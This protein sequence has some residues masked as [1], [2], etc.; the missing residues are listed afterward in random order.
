MI[1]FLERVRE[2]DFL[3]SFPGSNIRYVLSLSFEVAL[4]CE[5]Y[6]NLACSNLQGQRDPSISTEL[7]KVAIGFAYR[8]RNILGMTS[9]DTVFAQ[10]AMTKVDPIEKPRVLELLRP[11]LMRL[12]ILD[13]SKRYMN[14]IFMV[15]NLLLQ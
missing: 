5:Y 8:V 13:E 7:R 11:G 2:L 3:I 15:P 12:S 10:Q 4:T 9:M 14:S 1:A 6:N